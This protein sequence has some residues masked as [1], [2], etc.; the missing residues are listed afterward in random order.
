MPDPRAICL[1]VVQSASQPILR[2]PRQI[3]GRL[4][5]PL[6][7]TAR[8]L[9][10]KSPL[11]GHGAAVG[12][13]MASLGDLA[14][15]LKC[16][17][18]FGK[19][20]LWRDE[21]RLRWPSCPRLRCHSEPRCSVTF[22]GTYLRRQRRGAPLAL[23]GPR[24]RRPTRLPGK[25]ARRP[26]RLPGRSRRQRRHPLF[27]DGGLSPDRQSDSVAGKDVG[28]AGPRAIGFLQCSSITM[29]SVRGR[30]V[31]SAAASSASSACLPKGA[32]P[33]CR[34]HRDHRTRRS[35]D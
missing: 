35:R 20:P 2:Q 1:W 8:W 16:R 5:G 26:R 28:R 12:F 10:A 22:V 33:T 24:R 29:G 15:W 11:A 23:S 30:S 18:E 3:A 31:T 27:A 4:R 19:Q 13:A 34:S 32:H 9:S 14:F 25:R 6:D 17:R 21:A 7:A